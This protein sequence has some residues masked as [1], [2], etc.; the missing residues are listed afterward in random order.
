MS[1]PSLHRVEIVH[2]QLSASQRLVASIPRA[3]AR[4]VVRT[5]VPN[6][7]SEINLYDSSPERVIKQGNIHLFLNTPWEKETIM[8]GVS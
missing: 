4:E 2:S 6:T 3:L 8:V 7:R 5:T 1:W